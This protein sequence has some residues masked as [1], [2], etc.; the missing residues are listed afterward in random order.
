MVNSDDDVALVHEWV[1][2]R[3][4][5]NAWPNHQLMKPHHLS[6][7]FEYQSESLRITHWK[8]LTQN[9]YIYTAKQFY[10]QSEETINNRVICFFLE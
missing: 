9:I 3:S 8:V 2:E 5:K 7:H 1:S 4:D 10:H 6:L